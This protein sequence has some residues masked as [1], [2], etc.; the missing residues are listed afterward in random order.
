MRKLFLAFLL[1]LGVVTSV[2]LAFAA[3][4][5]SDEASLPQPRR[6]GSNPLMKFAGALRSSAGF[7]DT[8]YIGYSPGA[9]SAA[10]YWAIRASTTSAATTNVHR[11]PAAGCMWTW[12]PAGEATATGYIRN[13]SLQGWWPLAANFRL[14]YSPSRGDLR[15][16]ACD[17]DY[18]NQTSY[19]P[20]SSTGRNFGILGAWHR[21]HGN[22]NTGGVLAN[23]VNWAP[24]GG[25]YSAWCGLRQHADK[26]YVD[27][28]TSNPVNADAAL[29]TVVA[30]GSPNYFLFPGYCNNWDQMLYRNIDMTGFTGSDLTVNFKYSTQ[31][32]HDLDPNFC[33]WFDK[34]PLSQATNTSLTFHCADG[35]LV[36]GDKVTSPADSFMVYVGAP[37]ETNFQPFV[38]LCTSP[39]FGP[40]PIYDPLRRWFDEVIRSSEKNAG[41]FHLY[42]EL[43]SVTDSTN[44]TASILIP[45]TVLSPMLT[46]S[47]G[48]VRLVFRVKTNGLRSDESGTFNSHGR[49][50]AVVDDVT[51]S[52]SGGGGSSPAGWGTFE[53]ATDINNAVSGGSPNPTADLAW[54]ST[55]KPPL[56]IPHVEALGSPG[57]SYT[58]ACGA[59]VNAP[60]RICSMVGG[61]MTFGMHDLGEQIGNGK[62]FTGEASLFQLV[63]SPTIQMCSNDGVE[64][65]GPSA[66][67]PNT[68]NIK[69]PGN[70]GDAI[71]G[72]EIYID[73]ETYVRA[74]TFNLP[75]IGSGILYGWLYQSY[76]Q[77]DPFG[78]AGSAPFDHGITAWGQWIFG[79]QNYQAEDLCF[80]SIPGTTGQEGNVLSTGLVVFDDSRSE[81]Q[82]FPDSVKF[83]WYMEERNYFAVPTGQFP[84][85]GLYIDNTSLALIDGTPLPM[86]TSVFEWYQDSFPWNTLVVPAYDASFD[87]AG[88]IF[89]T[90][91]NAAQNSVP[92][93]ERW[94]IPADSI[95]VTALGNAP[96]RV[97]L[98]FRVLPGPGNYVIAG[99]PS[100]GL[101]KNPQAGNPV[102]GAGRTAA[103]PL[104]VSNSSN[105]WESYMFD[106]GKFGSTGSHATTVR[107]GTGGWDPN[108][109]NS[110]RCD[111]S[112][113]NQF[114]VLGRS[115]GIPP[116]VADTWSGTYHE[117]EFGI[118]AAP[119]Y[120]DPYDPL[121]TNKRGALGQPRH[122]C[123]IRTA[124][125]P[126]SNFDCVHNPPSSG[127]TPD[128]YDLS[129]VT[130]AGSGYDG[131]VNSSEYTKIIPDGLL[132]PGSH[133]EYFYRLAE[134]GVETMTGMM[135]DTNVVVPQLGE[136]NNDGQRWMEASALPDRW[137]ESGYSHPLGLV[138]G[139][140]AC[141]L[142]VDNQNSNTGDEYAWLAV[143]DTIG[144]TSNQKW[145]ASTGYHAKGGPSNINN[146]ADNID[147]AGRSGFIAEHGGSPGTTWD[148]FQIIGAEG[149]SPAGPLGGRLSFQGGVNPQY[150][151]QTQKSTPTLAQLEFFY[152]IL[153]YLNG[154]LNGNLLGPYDDRSTDDVKMIENWLKDGNTSTLN[155]V[156]ITTGDGFVENNDLLGGAQSG[157]NSSYLGVSLQSPAY[158]N[159]SGITTNTV[160]LT[161]VNP[162]ALFV[163]GKYW[164]VRNTCQHTD[165]VL[166]IA[167]GPVA[168]FTSRLASYPDPDV[169]DSKLFTAVMLKAWNTN[170]PWAAMTCGFDILD[171]VSRFGIDSKGRSSFFYDV[172]TKVFNGVCTVTGTPIVGLDV[173]NLGD[174]KMFSDFVSLRN[175]P[176]A[177]GMAKIHF[178]IARDDQVTVKIFDVGGRLVRT[179]ADRQFKAGEHDLVWDGT[180]NGGRSV[181]RGVYFTQVRYRNSAFSDAK[182]L[183]VLK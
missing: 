176:L 180:D 150:A 101:A 153:L 116:V 83:G 118:A 6:G 56:T 68:I 146:P 105:F 89:R 157:L 114:P 66:A 128:V 139:G 15:I 23:H 127:V 36:A 84:I 20:R 177:S 169:N 17:L 76:P 148:F 107:A 55:A 63:M 108:H 7:G 61:V 126:I 79:Q 45:N 72:N 112:G 34:D 85:G 11:P 30:T 164:G 26:Q 1:L 73:Y 161:P 181:S 183:T 21:D 27:P 147:R 96:L 163:A 170:S 167:A 119:E 178:G 144:A 43:L 81:Y 16:P 104:G 156:F 141:M 129:Y 74:A 39:A 140:H 158:R 98:I 166:D 82:E 102:T 149:S 40:R 111:T 110:A 78:V 124:G 142:V 94:D 106:D 75:V 133:I 58:D 171:L 31:L 97:D 25:S 115:S 117:S 8:T 5:F 162:G 130:A 92:R 33:G 67:W 165:E 42:K 99:V 88:T 52:I 174:G 54:R 86:S 155:R 168:A 135:P 69:A 28:I 103:N 95:Y 70:Q 60:G 175:N 100:S 13:D 136:R 50:A 12:D 80:R 91:I 65:P 131:N 182:K 47:G 3:D 93:I 22:R 38:D 109:W 57:V 154:N 14:F 37:T 120:G 29:Y 132:T 125:A 134:A 41:S 51:Y 46:A 48:K 151:P 123:F 138:T 121:P 32:S 49:G 9:G 159:D 59:D 53:N 152:K 64:G 10:N 143:A 137:K 77:T 173:P 62:N 71:A 19:S 24:L 44:T 145:G 179:L 113:T 2:G 18:G 160:D 172:F 4:D 90:G 35:N 87:T 122:R